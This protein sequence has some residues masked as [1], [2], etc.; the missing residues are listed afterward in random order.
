[1]HPCGYVVETERVRWLA[2]VRNVMIG[3]EGMDRSVLLDIAQKAGGTDVSSYLS[4]GNLTFETRGKQPEPFV[5]AIEAGV[6]RVLGRPELVSMRPLPWLRDLVSTDCFDGFESSEWV[7]EVAFLRHNSPPLDVSLLDDPQ[8]TVIVD[9]RTREV[10][11]ARPRTG[12]QRPH[13]NRLVERATGVQA[14]SRGWSTLR[15]IADRAA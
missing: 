8:R 5:T 9:V 7:L 14:T 1:M 10:L 15:R 3:R 2:L 13:V 11:A 6:Q 4:T 12:G